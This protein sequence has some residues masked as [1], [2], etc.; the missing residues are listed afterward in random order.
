M[1]EWLRR[2]TRNQMGSSRVGSNPTRSDKWF[3]RIEF[4]YLH[5]SF[6]VLSSNDLLNVVTGVHG[7]VHHKVFILILFSKCNLEEV[8][9]SKQRKKRLHKIPRRKKQQKRRGHPG[10]NQ[11]PLDL[12]SNALPLSYIP[13]KMKAK[14]YL[15]N[16]K[17]HT[18]FF[19]KKTKERIAFSNTSPSCFPCHL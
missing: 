8:T 9:C 19:Q 11:G 18:F 14:A 5:T 4:H 3:C 17:L 12:Q 15:T 10:L 2:L 7:V 1:A 6:F 16:L 13:M